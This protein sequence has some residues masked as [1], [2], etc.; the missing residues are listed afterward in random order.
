MKLFAI[1]T[2]LTAPLAAG[3][4]TASAQPLQAVQERGAVL[5]GVSQGLYGFSIADDKGNWSGFDV[6][7]CRAIEAAIFNDAGKVKFV[8]LP[9][10]D[11]FAALKSGAV[12]VLSR[13]TTWTMS[14]ESSLGLI[15]AGITYYDGQ[16]F[17]VPAALNVESALELGDK[18]V[19]TQ[20]G[21][22]TE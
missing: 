18:S 10:T 14:R 8:P 12:D 21:T 7:L 2:A 6:D 11:R 15:F 4:P 22:T 13:N 20:T 3:T 1:A 16:G 19:C 9:A 5:S 17:L